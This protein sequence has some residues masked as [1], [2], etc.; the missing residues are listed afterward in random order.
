MKQPDVESVVDVKTVVQLQA[1]KPVCPVRSDLS[2]HI[3]PETLN[4]DI[5]DTSVNDVDVC[6]LSSSRTIEKTLT[7]P[8]CMIPCPRRCDV[9]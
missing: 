6:W 3:H 5:V 8:R 7:F 9:P 2:G 4:T 1:G